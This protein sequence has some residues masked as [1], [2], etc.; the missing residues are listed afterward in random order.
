MHP[1][2]PHLLELQKLDQLIASLRTDVES[3]PKRM[4][5]AD[6]K[7]NGARAAVSSSKEAL[8]QTL[9]QRKKFELD[10]NQWKD[11]AR[12]YRDQ[13]A[14]VK[15]NESYKALQHEIANAEKEVSLAEDRVLEQ[16]MALEETERQ[17]KHFEADLREA[18]QVVAKEKK[19]IEIQYVTQKDKLAKDLTGREE[20]AKKVP[21]DL[22][23]LYSRIAKRNPGSVMAEVRDNQCRACGM[24]VLPHTI[25]LLNSEV[26]EE[27]FRCETCGRILYSLQPIPHASSPESVG[28][29]ASGGS[30]SS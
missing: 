16:M 26:D 19:Q 23:E 12:K 30:V 15:T 28:G 6:T 13:S 18:E 3:L 27:V 11:R 1:A 22:L 8:T 25:Q 21:P 29:A 10:A 5:E 2:I 7:L 20:I 14:A 4:R 9:T 17:I 24:R